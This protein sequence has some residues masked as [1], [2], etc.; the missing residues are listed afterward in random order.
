ML[1]IL[2]SL[3]LKRIFFSALGNFFFLGLYHHDASAL[4]YKVPFLGDVIGENQEVKAGLAVTLTELAQQYD[5]GMYEIARANP[6]LN[7]KRLQPSASVI[8]PAQFILP[9]APREGIVLNLADMRVFYYH[10]DGNTV[11]TYPVGVGRQGWSTPRGITRIMSKE[12][13]PAWHPPASIRRE[14]ARRGKTLP[15]VVPPGPH[16]PLGHYKMSL[17]FPGILMHGTTQPASIGLYSSHG[18]IRLYNADIKE[19]FYMVPI[20]TSVR[21]VY[22]PHDNE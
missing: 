6:H 12:E 4:T 17:G 11:T 3:N 21:V 8:I 16:N 14:A 13:N 7:R 9:S 10:P 20:G 19:L 2:T 5:I 18:C 1:N 22:E 15:L